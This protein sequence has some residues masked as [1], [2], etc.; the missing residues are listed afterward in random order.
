[1][2]ILLNV[3]V[4]M[5]LLCLFYNICGWGILFIVCLLTYGNDEI[6]DDRKLSFA[7]TTSIGILS[8]ILVAIL[9]IYT[10]IF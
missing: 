1:M 3:I 5:C 8:A 9:A 6:T 10:F 2:S 4:T 7:Y